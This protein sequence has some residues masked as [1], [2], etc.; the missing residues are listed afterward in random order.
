MYSEIMT[1]PEGGFYSAED[2]DSEGVEG[3][4]YVWSQEEVNQVLGK[5]D[6][7]YFG[8]SY[9]FLDAGNFVEEATRERTGLN[10]PHLK[11]RLP[12]EKRA[13]LEQ[14][15]E[16]LF[17]ERTK[18][19]HPLKDDKILTD[20]NG[21]MIAAF[22]RYGWVTG[23]EAVVK[24][25]VRAASF[26]KAH[27]YTEKG[28]LHHRFRNGKSGLQANLDDYSFLVWGLVELY[29]AT[30][31]HAWLKL[32]LELHESM[33]ERFWDKDEGRLLFFTF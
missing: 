16:R 25:A 30:F 18:R 4:F 26:I 31:D 23:N 14:S 12:K 32:A 22:A 33:I 1:S 27:L 8:E 7:T 13:V 17:N 11:N 19:V 2:A 5:E 24:H 9:Q 28:Q 15:R 6:G 3:K 20:W 10:I 29:Q 21:L